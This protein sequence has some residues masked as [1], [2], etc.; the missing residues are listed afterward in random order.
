MYKNLSLKTRSIAINTGICIAL[1]G[2][3]LALFYL[4]PVHYVFLI[5][6]DMPVEYATTTAYLA[7][8]CVLAWAMIQNRDARTLINVT[9][10]LFM[11]FVAME[12][13]SWG[14]RIFGIG[15]SDFFMEH[16]HQR[17]LNIHNLGFVRY[18]KIIFHNGMALWMVLSL[19]S[20]DKLGPLGRFLRWVRLPKI[21]ACTLPYFVL[22]LIFVHFGVTPKSEELNELIFAYGFALLSLDIYY[23]TGPTHKQDRLHIVPAWLLTGSIIASAVM[24]ATFWSWPD[25]LRSRMNLFAVREYPQ[26]KLYAQ[27]DRIYEYLII[28]P[29]LQNPDTLY[30]YGAYLKQRGESER[31]RSIL[32]MALEEKKGQIAGGAPSGYTYYLMANIYSLLGMPDDEKRALTRA[33]TLYE[34]EIAEIK[35]DMRNGKT[36]KK[37]GQK[38]LRCAYEEIADVHARVGN[39]DQAG[40]YRTLLDKQNRETGN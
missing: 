4:F 27:A 1:F 39:Q 36:L 40:T 31:A 38:M 33:L 29:E 11:L 2:A 25:I 22:A 14:Q 5:S 16:N 26:R 30:N 34:S 13:I 19:I 32:L 7:G 20:W 37:L 24:L 3:I 15:S 21:P 6:E 23:E 28:R 35:N 9:L 8:C 17:E 10:I 18:T 12:E